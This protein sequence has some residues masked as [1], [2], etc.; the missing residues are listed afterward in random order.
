MMGQL[1]VVDSTMLRLEDSLLLQAELAY[2]EVLQLDPN[3]TFAYFNLGLVL[4]TS[5]RLEEAENQ[6]GLAA[7]VRGNFIE[8]NFNRGLIRLILGKT[9]QGCEDLSLAGELGLTSSYNI[10]KRYCE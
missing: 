3:M 4:A 6:F 8:A 5:E 1:D 9:K 2:R 7:S 10:I